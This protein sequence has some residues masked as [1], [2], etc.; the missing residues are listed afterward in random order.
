M[1]KFIAALSVV[2]IV[3]ATT[4]SA[5]GLEAP[6][7]EPPVAVDAGGPSS[8]ASPWLLLPLLLGGVLL[9]TSGT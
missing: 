4:A 3:S 7:V 6:A 1:K 5:G 8:S 2:T 9:A